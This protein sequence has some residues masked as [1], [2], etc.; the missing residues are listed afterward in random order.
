MVA[1]YA[2]I[3]GLRRA[4][5][6]T[7]IMPVTNLLERLNEEI[8]RRTY[9]VRIFPNAAVGL[10]TGRSGDTQPPKFP[11]DLGLDLAIVPSLQRVWPAWGD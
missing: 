7:S 1:P 10:D 9:V 8:K 4:R 6:A 2:K 3:T 5:V 11:A